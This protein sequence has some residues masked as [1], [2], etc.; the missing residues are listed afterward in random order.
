MKL[1]FV[2]CSY[3]TSEENNFIKSILTLILPF[4]PQKFNHSMSLNSPNFLN[5]KTH[6]CDY[7]LVRIINMKYFQMSFLIIIVAYLLSCQNANIIT[8]SSPSQIDGATW[9]SYNIDSTFGSNGCG[10][11]FANYNSLEISYMFNESKFT[12]RIFHS[13]GNNCKP[14][15]SHT[16]TIKSGDSIISIIHFPVSP[17]P[18]GF[19]GYT[20]DTGFC[21]FYHDSLILDYKSRSIKDTFYYRLS[22]NIDTLFLVKDSIESQFVKIIQ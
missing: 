15:T 2:N 9:R 14:C 7:Y 4:R 22:I 18:V 19:W 3:R 8:T 12:K 20:I 10:T 11:G 21:Y 13:Y 5:L 1:Y 17:C 6:S 16:D